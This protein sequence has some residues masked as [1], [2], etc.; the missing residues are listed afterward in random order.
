MADEQDQTT[1]YEGPIKP[2]SPI[3]HSAI[4]DEFKKQQ[5]QIDEL[6]RRL[7][8]VEERLARGNEG[9]RAM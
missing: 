9:D 6:R 2:G 5:H 3:G 8:T 1:A 7:K 4:N